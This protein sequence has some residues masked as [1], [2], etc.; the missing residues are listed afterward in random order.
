MSDQP[1]KRTVLVVVPSIQ[2]IAGHLTGAGF[3]KGIDH[4]GTIT[5]ELEGEDAFDL[6]RRVAELE[7]EVRTTTSGYNAEILTARQYTAAR[8]P[9]RKR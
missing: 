4:E 3:I 5:L 2:E 1:I 6:G 7:G 9:K 8:T